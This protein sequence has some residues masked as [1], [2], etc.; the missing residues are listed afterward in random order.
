MHDASSR[1][2]Y[3]TLFL[4]LAAPASAQDHVAE[5]GLVAWR[6]SPDLVLSTDAL[7]GSSRDEVDFVREFGLEDTWFPEFRAAFGRNHKFRLSYVKFNYEADA[8]IQRTFTF[9]G[10][11]F[12]RGTSASTD[13]DW[14]LWTFGYEWD[15]VSRERGYFGIVADLKY[16]QIKASVDSP[17]LRSTAEADTRAPVPTI[18]AAGRA[19]VTPMVA[20][21]G[22]WTG[23]KVSAG[24]FDARFTDFAINATIMPS[25]RIGVGAQIGYRSVVADYVVDEDSGDLKMQ[26]PYFGAIARF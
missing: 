7:A 6:T 24:D 25:P 12:T 20:I 2:V 10:R 21:T 11:T 5:L 4:L 26:G 23:L 22:E 16:N 13:I 9:Q 15:V 8:T 3:G 18:G 17:A 19:Y 14:S 1:L